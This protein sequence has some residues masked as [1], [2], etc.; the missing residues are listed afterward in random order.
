[1]THLLC[2]GLG[3]SARVLAKRA[4]AGG[5]HVHGTS[6][7]DAGVAH[8]REAGFEASVMPG[9]TPSAEAAV[10]CAAASHILVSVPPVA[11]GDLVLRHHEIDLTK[12]AG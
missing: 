11:E 6:R 4:L 1:M 12:S 3:Y 5:W 7:T 10:A 2:F 9:D 8:L